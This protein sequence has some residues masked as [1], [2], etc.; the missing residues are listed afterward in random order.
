MVLLSPMTT[1]KYRRPRKTQGLLRGRR[2][3]GGLSQSARGLCR[4]GPRGSADS[5]FAARY[6]WRCL[7]RG[8]RPHLGKSC[9][10]AGSVQVHKEVLAVLEKVMTRYGL[11]GYIRIDNRP[12]FI[13]A[14][15]QQWLIE[16][17]IKTIYIDPGSPWQNGYIES[18]HSRFCDEC[19]D[20]EIF[21]NLREA[22]VAISDWLLHYKQERFDCRLG[23][24]SPE[25]FIK[26]K[27][28]TF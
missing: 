9:Q 7:Q 28:L 18:F 11:P 5:R 16:N 27:T 20:R 24:R 25:K 14:I 23:Y 8:V 2:Y 4:T 22:C 17:Q 26:T 3:C 19:L 6:F 13:A 10:A 1:I 12:E 21:L 15:V